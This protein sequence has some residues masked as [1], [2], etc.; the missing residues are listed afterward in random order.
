MCELLRKKFAHSPYSFD[1][2]FPFLQFYLPRGHQNVYRNISE[3]C[4]EQFSIL[5]VRKLQLKETQGLFWRI[6]PATTT[7]WETP[8]LNKGWLRSLLGLSST[9]TRKIYK[10]EVYREC[11]KA[12]FMLNTSNN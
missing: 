9:H 3:F 8:N 5:K 12:K 2:P 1:R 10:P 11:S 7:S 6:L 4:H